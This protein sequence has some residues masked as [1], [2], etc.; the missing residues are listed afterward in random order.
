M[1]HLNLTTSRTFR[2]SSAT[3]SATGGGAYCLGGR[4]CSP[5]AELD[6]SF[7]LD[8]LA[9]HFADT[10]DELLMRLFGSLFKFLSKLFLLCHPSYQPALENCLSDCD[11]ESLCVS[12]RE[13]S[14]VLAYDA[15]QVQDAERVR[16]HVQTLHFY[17]YSLLRRAK[18]CLFFVY[19]FS[20][21]YCTDAATNTNL[22]P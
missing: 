9:L 13:M 2:T 8:R 22:T 14:E 21:Y 1:Q 12:S 18:T 20:L 11:V 6:V 16:A 19:F 7:F 10:G 5:A 4:P 3:S 15:A 17:C